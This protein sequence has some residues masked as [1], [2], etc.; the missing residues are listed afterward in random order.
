M[1]ERIK[2][3]FFDELNDFL[4]LRQ[5]NLQLD[6]ELKKPRSVKDLIESIGVPHT[7]IGH[8]LSNGKAVDFNYPVSNGELIH[9][10]PI[11]DEIS[12]LNSPDPFA[13]HPAVQGFLLDVH[14]G[15]LAAYLRMLGFDCI[16]R[17]DYDDSALADISAEQNRIL[18]TCDR[19][20]LMRKKINYGYFVRHRQPRLQLLEII[21]RFKL[22]DKLRPFTR[23]VHCNGIT[24]P[25]SKQTI[26]HLLEPKTRKYYDE[27]YQCSECKK[28][29]WKGSHYQKMK[30]MVDQLV[31]QQISKS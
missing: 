21:A 27:F 4:P 19:R 18:L 22:H 24:Q 8:I 13:V 28:I 30:I 6:I 5:N 25:V 26:E 3:R 7:E 31:K 14:L 9:V 1:T 17:N 2:I 15:R 16:Y 10:Y 12:S 29:Y 20:L 11:R 23:C